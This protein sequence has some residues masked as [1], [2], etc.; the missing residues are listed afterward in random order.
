MPRLLWNVWICLQSVKE[1]SK[2]TTF[3]FRFCWVLYGVGFGQVRVLAHFFL[4]S[5]SGSVRLSVK[6]VFWFCSFLLS[7]SFPSLAN[8]V[9][10]IGSEVRYLWPAG[11]GPLSDAG[12]VPAALY[13]VGPRVGVALVGVQQ[14][15]VERH[16]HRLS[17]AFTDSDHLATI[18]RAL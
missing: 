17:T 12:V 8:M 2:N 1:P 13:V 11:C 10:V 3:G 14:R 15:P 16:A 4:L 18:R 9:V 6:P 5:G 7:G